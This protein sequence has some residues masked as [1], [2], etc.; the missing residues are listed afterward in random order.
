MDVY[1]HAWEAV[2]TETVAIAEGSE[3]E[4]ADRGEILQEVQELKVTV[5]YIIS[6]RPFL[7]NIPKGQGDLAA[8]T[9]A[10]TVHCP[11]M[12]L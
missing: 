7:R 6:S 3:F 8:S 4:G 9:H 12:S 5:S 1:R 11:T 10:I 2:C